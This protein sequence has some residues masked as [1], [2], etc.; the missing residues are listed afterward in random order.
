MAAPHN[1][2]E[3]RYLRAE[4]WSEVRRLMSEPKAELAP[5]A[6]AKAEVLVAS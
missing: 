1:R 3:K 2:D 6:S 4:G 5:T